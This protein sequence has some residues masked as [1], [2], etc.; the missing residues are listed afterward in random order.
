MVSNC[1]KTEK[2]FRGISVNLCVGTKMRRNSCQSGKWVAIGEL[3]LK[4]GSS[5]KVGEKVGE[6]R[7]FSSTMK[8]RVE[9]SSFRVRS[10]VP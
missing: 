2:Q 10:Q 7:E 9:V 5:F 6:K 8:L 3:A 4:F 1:E